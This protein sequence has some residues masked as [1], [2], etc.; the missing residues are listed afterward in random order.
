[1]S[2]STDERVAFLSGQVHALVSFALA[3]AQSFPDRALLRQEF[4]SASQGGL[5]KLEN[6]LTSDRS[7]LG[8]QDV[9]E[10]IQ[11]TLGEKFRETD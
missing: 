3:V 5:A 8:F 4:E 7:I 6:S 11:T 2:R 1:M 10:K 9:A